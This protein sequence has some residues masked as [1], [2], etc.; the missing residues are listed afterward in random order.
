MRLPEHAWRQRVGK[1]LLILLAVM[2]LGLFAWIGVSSS[3]TAGQI[4]GV[5]G[6]AVA[7]A[8]LALALAPF[9]QPPPPANERELADIL[10][11]TLQGQWDDEV[12]ARRLRD[13]S[14]ILLA[15]SATERAVADSPDAIAGPAGTRIRSQALEGRLQGGFDDAIRRLAD[16][17]RQIPSGRLVVLGEP[18]AGK[19]VL[20]VMLVLG[21]LGRRENDAAVPVLLSVSTWDPVS[22]SLDDWIV[23]SLAT[24]YYNGR[25]EVPRRLLDRRLLLPVLDGLDEM[26]E[27]ARRSA[28]RGINLARGDG[29]GVIVTCRSAEYEDVIEGGAPVLRRAPVVE[30]RPVPARDALAYLRAVEWP[31][32]T[33]WSKVYERLEAEPGSAVSTAL[34]TPLMLSLARTVH[35]HCP[36][37][38][39]SLLD[40]DSRHEVEDYLVDRVIL[41][42]YAPLQVPGDPACADPDWRVQADQAE[43]WLTYLARYLHQHRERDL[44][45]W[46]MG[47]RLLSRWAGPAIGIGLGVL[48]MLAVSAGATLLMHDARTDDILAAGAGTGG[49]F[50]VLAMFIWYAAPERPPG[51]LSFAVRGS[52]GRLRRGFATGLALTAIPAVPVMAAG[53][54]TI[55]I[56]PVGW[57]ASVVRDY[58]HGLT[59]LVALASSIGLALAVHNWLDAPPE[60]STRANP[61]DFLVQ[62]RKSSL[63]AA[64]CAGTVLALSAFPLLAIALSVGIVIVAVAS[65][66]SNEPLIAEAADLISDGFEGGP[67]VAASVCGA[68]AVLVLLIL[69]TRAWPRFLLTRLVLGAQRRLPWHLMRFLADA[70]ERQL[71]RQ[72]GGTYQFRHIRLQE[73]LASRSLA[74]DREPSDPGVVI[75]QR[76][77]RAG[78]VAAVLVALSLVLSTA[79]PD[80]TSQATSITGSVER[81][82]FGQDGSTL[83]TVVKGGATRWNAAT[84]R[85][86][87]IRSHP[88]VGPA[89][90]VGLTEKASGLIVVF[91]FHAGKVS[92]W[93]ADTGKQWKKPKAVGIREYFEKGYR[94][95]YYPFYAFALSGDGTRLAVEAD[96][97]LLVWD[98]AEDTPV[99][100]DRR[101]D[102][103][104]ITLNRSD[105]ALNEDGT[106]LTQYSKDGEG[107]GPAIVRWWDLGSA[108]KEG[109]PPSL[110][111]EEGRSEVDLEDYQHSITLSGDGTRLAAARD[112]EVRVWDTRQKRKVAD[113]TGPIASIYC[114]ALNEN[115]STLAATAERNTRFWTL[116][117]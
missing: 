42:A 60:R 48:V 44:A 104:D 39:A 88:K 46:L 71:L 31:E 47:G 12:M 116:G 67:A 38:P 83:V 52:L 84:G 37:S 117:P 5:A 50:A 90:S 15:W 17:Y 33:D 25:P 100:L 89:S 4:T 82:A 109:P 91:D 34:S 19:T 70:R 6:L 54:V 62:D 101:P 64:L 96:G 80:D 99:V 77:Q 32:G 85:K 68:G 112:N 115:G 76:R 36:D 18:G 13:P 113:L 108:V 26:P 2:S 106:R 81:M 65:G 41:A 79:L 93:D 63:T 61:L 98:V 102:S 29:R 24:A 35:Q 94:G 23:Q 56:D 69:L 105:I 92:R 78:T 14:V 22:E 110:G 8:G 87:E 107:A 103:T 72:S 20:A 16:G 51:R 58:F 43:R 55:S 21:L 27:S 10:A 74:K 95:R 1:L 28:V 86:I 57:S 49:G 66:W 30:V 45:W 3:D 75:R 11:E 40:H 9:L 114:L 97:Q 73:R 7:L 59:L 53:A 111:E